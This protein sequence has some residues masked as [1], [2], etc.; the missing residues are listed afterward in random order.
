MK[1]FAS[2]GILILIIFISA[3]A[4]I[5][6]LTGGEK[7]TIPPKFVKSIPPEQGKNFKGDKIS[8][9][10]DEFFVLDNLNAVFL[11]SPPLLKKP[12]FK[13]KRKTLLI[14]LH[15]A[16]KDTTT[17]TFLF[18]NAIKDYH[19]GNKIHDFRFVFSTG[20]TIDTMEV[21]G[22]VIDAKTHKKQAD[23]LVMLYYNHTDSV[24]IKEKPYYIAKTDTSGKFNINFIK[25]G[26][27]K[28]FAL[29][30][31][32]AN[33]NFNLPQEKIA[34]IDSFIIPK[35]KTETKI[36]SFKAGSVLHFGDDD[37]KGDTLKKDTVIITKKYIYTP[38]NIILFAFTED[39]L[40]QYLINSERPVKEK[41]VFLF[42]KTT[43]NV[44]ISGLNFTLNPK[45][46]F[47]EK[48]DSGKSII[49]WLN[50]KNLFGKDTVRFTFSYFNKDSV[51]NLFSQ[52]DTTALIFNNNA[53][54]IIHRISVSDSESD[55]DFFKDF[56]I[57]TE[58][59]ILK[60]DTSKIKLFMLFDTLVSDTKKQELLKSYRPT[61]DTLIFSLKRPFV[62]R[63]YIEALNFDTVPQWSVKNYSDKRK[64]L[65]C[66]IKNKTI[67]QKDTLKIILHYDNAFFRGQ[68]QKFSD[69]LNLPLYK[70]NLISAL[71]TTADTLTFNFK[72]K[73]S[74]NTT[75][76]LTE[77]NPEN[78]YRRIKSSD[79]KKLVLKIINKNLIE[80]DTLML[81][82]RT[83]DYDNT[84][85]DKIYFEYLKN[86][87]FKHKR[88]KLNK[89]HRLQ[90]NKF[91]LIFNK[92]L[93][94]DVK[95]KTLDSVKDIHPFI[96][97]YNTKKDTLNC[98]ITDKNFINND[99]LNVII[100]YKE[101][102][103]RGIINHADTLNLIY[104]KPRRKHRRHFTEN[105]T[106][107]GTET[108]DKTTTENT[109]SVS[110]KLPVKYTLIKDSVSERKYHIKYNRKEGSSYILKLDTF[111]FENYQN[112][113]SEFKEFKFKVR[114]KDDYGNIIL[115]ISQ[116]KAFGD[117]NFYTKSD[118]TSVDSA[119]YSVLPEGQ[120]IL[121]LYDKDNNLLKTEYLTQDTIITYNNI[122]AGNYHLEM[123][124]D[125]N[126]NK[127]YDTGN[128]LK[129]KQ[130]ERIIYYPND[131][132]IKPKWD[133]S[134]D[135]KFTELNKL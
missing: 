78:W 3:C 127:K 68:I 87:I 91:Y 107:K 129:H 39:N 46:S 111:A 92:P 106:K 6:T 63:F 77:N 26:K 76:E 123:I 118:T 44:K 1:K 33:L 35:I 29:K 125:K 85:G 93:V 109:K 5:G 70:Q 8:I 27:Y 37:A 128:Y 96:I 74:A 89:I 22:V 58:T 103:K 23:L 95:I 51:G 80:E 112:E 57:E 83:L 49:V 40:S 21:S 36:D 34:F 60:A 13:I 73:I 4:Q 115:N 105:Q 134:V 94:S 32:D 69:T 59:P 31:N 61:P 71:R 56:T 24:P 132:I 65:I 90:K 54:T 11:S 41:C 20:N 99:T 2:Y 122:V 86:V 116:I 45:N 18:G 43:E 62:N 66:K 19:E 119:A 53:D 16:L 79:N 102:Y 101:K 9:M 133:N 7:D 117:K 48:Q 14:K 75:V 97:N 100:L 120:V 64:K 130:P 121:N 135:I 98:E 131:I 67:S 15:E 126:N 124:W 25:P 30:D 12:D 17:Y 104:K 52:T 72:K 108:Q 88:Q 113:F 82:I 55:V 47:V 110:L 81:K 38:D 42:N 84:A 50:D 10:F 114:T 28:I